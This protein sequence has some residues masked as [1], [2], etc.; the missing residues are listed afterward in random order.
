MAKTKLEKKLE[1][2]SPQQKK[3]ALEM[4]SSN[5]GIPQ[6]GTWTAKNQSGKKT[7]KND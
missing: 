7:Q 5:L 1:K 3:A 2:M 6:G 4:I